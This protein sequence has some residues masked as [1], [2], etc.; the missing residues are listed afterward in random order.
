MLKGRFVYLFFKLLW[1]RLL[2]CKKSFVGKSNAQQSLRR[3]HCFIYRSEVPNN[4]QIKNYIDTLQ[5]DIGKQISKVYSV[6][7]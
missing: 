1:I 4:C 5:T 7:S 6:E 2:E 3:K